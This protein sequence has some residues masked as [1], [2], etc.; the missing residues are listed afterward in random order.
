MFA[1]LLTT[2]LLHP[3]HE[4]VA[5]V[6][7]NQQSKRLEVALR[8][9]V[10]DEQWLARKYGPRKDVASWALKYLR[11]RFRVGDRQAAEVNPDQPADKPDPARYHWVGRDQ[12]GSHVWWYFEIE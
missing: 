7:W 4:T 5:E 12:Q 6:E 10:L 3:V 2:I 9:D 11:G 1:A 8:L